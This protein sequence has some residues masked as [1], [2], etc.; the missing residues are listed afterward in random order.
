[1]VQTVRWSLQHF[2]SLQNHLNHRF[3][4][5]GFIL[6]VKLPN[7]Y[8][9]LSRVAPLNSASLAGSLPGVL[10]QVPPLILTSAVSVNTEL[11][12]SI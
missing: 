6:I 9:L 4:A 7:I 5:L 8:K 1:M 2:H 3:I 12:L 10:D 11:N